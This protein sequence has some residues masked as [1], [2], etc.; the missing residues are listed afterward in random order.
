MDVK[1]RRKSRAVVKACGTYTNVILKGEFTGKTFY[2]DSQK[3]SRNAG[4][5]LARP[6]AANRPPYGR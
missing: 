4:T 6:T 2:S 3:F 1:P 5:L